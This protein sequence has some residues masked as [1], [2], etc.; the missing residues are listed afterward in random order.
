[1]PTQMPQL[2]EFLSCPLCGKIFNDKDKKPIS[3]GCGHTVC[4][5]CLVNLQNMKCPYDQ[6]VITKTVDELPVN[7]ALLQLVGAAIPEEERTQSAVVKENSHYES[8]KKCIEELAVNMKS[9]TDDESDNEDETSQ[10]SQ[11]GNTLHQGASSNSILSR[12]MQRKLVTLINCQLVEE[13]GRARAMRA[14]RSLG[15]RTVAELILQHQNPQQLSANLWAAVRA[16][17]CQFLGP[18]MQAEVLKLILLALEDGSALARKVLVLFVVQRLEAT[19]IQASKTAIGHVVQLLY[20]ASCFKVTKRDE[21]SSLMQLKEEFRTYEALRREHDSQIVQIAMEAG[22]RISPEQWSSL[23]YGDSGHKSHMQSI[24]DKL[25]S[26][27]SF[28]QSINE[29]MIALQRTNDPGQLQSLHPHLDFLAKIQVEPSQDK[30]VPSWENL[31]AILRALKTVVQGLINYLNNHSHKKSD[32]TQAAQNLRYK[33]SMCRDFSMNKS[34]PRGANCTFAHSEDELERFRAKKKFGVKLYPSL[35]PT[36]A[37]LT[38]KEKEELALVN[39]TTDDKLDSRGVGSPVTPHKTDGPA[40]KSLPMMNIVKPMMVPTT[41]SVVSLT[42]NATISIA[43]TSSVAATSSI[44][45]VSGLHGT[46]QRSSFSR[47]SDVVYY[48]T[49]GERHPI[50]HASISQPSVIPPQMGQPI[51]PQSAMSQPLIPQNRI[52]QPLIPQN[53]M[54]QP[55]LTQVGVNQSMI[56][57]VPHAH[58]GQTPIPHASVNQTPAFHHVPPMPPPNIHPLSHAVNQPYNL[59]NSRPAPTGAAAR[60]PTPSFPPAIQYNPDQQS[61]ACSHIYHGYM[62]DGQTPCPTYPEPWVHQQSPFPCPDNSLNPASSFYR[63]KYSYQLPPA[64]QPVT[65]DPVQSPSIQEQFTSQDNSL[66]DLK[67]RRKE[68]LSQIHSNIQLTPIHQESTEIDTSHHTSPQNNLEV[69]KHK[70]E[71]IPQHFSSRGANSGNFGSSQ[72]PNVSNGLTQ[73][74]KAYTILK[75]ELSRNPQD[76]PDPREFSWTTPISVNSVLKVQNSL[77]GEQ[78][79]TISRTLQENTVQNM[80]PEMTIPGW[81]RPEESSQPTS[82]ASSDEDLE[83][84]GGSYYDPWSTFDWSSQA[85]KH[86]KQDEKKCEYSGTN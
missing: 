72:C 21:T 57:M 32:L 31:D 1:M 45:S 5:I 54:G 33:T 68:I 27:Q 59:S 22:L 74:E 84:D 86:D 82:S 18:E 39:K 40:V 78:V 23:L 41:T 66:Q 17:G 8:C 83:T 28:S 35:V 70:R 34:C 42:T 9:L 26:P 56:P 6:G 49:T 29:L 63:D 60:Y 25:Q 61:S 3:L 58:V 73:T 76:A 81:S 4:R 38:A 12:P 11:N 37:G 53:R 65:I 71:R 10:L 36:F 46:P 19:F 55:L 43:A 52:G 14:A 80:L 77:Q 48:S 24:I 69:M 47:Q 13:E 20:R 50:S 30:Q 79:V 44:T 85:I 15:E 67:Y 7:Y 51:V 75:K 64:P 16:R 2:K 62:C